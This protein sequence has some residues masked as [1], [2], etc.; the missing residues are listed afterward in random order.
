[1]AG[2][3]D[4]ELVHVREFLRPLHELAPDEEKFCAR[5]AKEVEEMIKEIK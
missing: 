5:R 1:V 4:E 2:G 3:A